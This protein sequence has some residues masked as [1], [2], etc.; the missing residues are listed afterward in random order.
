M[1]F[2]EVGDAVCDNARFAAPRARQ[3]EKRSIGVLDG[4]ALDII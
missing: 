1:V 2:D 4:F 3:N